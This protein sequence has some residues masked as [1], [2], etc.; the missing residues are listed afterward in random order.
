M[1]LLVPPQFVKDINRFSGF[2]SISSKY[3]NKSTK[4]LFLTVENKN[5]LINELYKLLCNREYVSHIVSGLDHYTEI[6]QNTDLHKRFV[7]CRKQLEIM[8]PDIIVDW[9]LPYREDKAIKNP[10]Q[11]LSLINKDFLDT[12]ARTLIQNPESVIPDFY[13]YDP[14]TEI[15][16]K[17]EWGYGASSYSDGTWHPEHLFTES[18]RNRQN[19]YWIPVEVSFDTNPPGSPFHPRNDHYNLRSRNA[20]CKQPDQ[21][22]TFI[23]NPTTTSWD[24]LNR[25]DQL[26]PNFQ[27]IPSLIDYL[28]EPDYPIFNNGKA[29][30]PYAPG[31]GPGNRY[32]YDFYG[33]KGFSSGGTF[34]RWQYSMN[35]RYYDRDNS[36]GLREGGRSERRI[37]RPNGYDMSALT[38]KSSY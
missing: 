7:K 20:G 29:N 5:Y 6:E 36:D 27:D 14:Q 37:Q 13:E 4:G 15:H 28:E 2:I 21:R 33:D 10:I 38:S 18:E 22:E 19:P 9:M 35:H 26:H 3:G 8:I 11:E 25:I 1:S 17:E 12:T 23:A 34:P 32:A 16:H 30:L 31:P 24:D